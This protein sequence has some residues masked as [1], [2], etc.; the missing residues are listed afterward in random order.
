MMSGKRVVV[1]NPAERE[2]D[3][4]RAVQRLRQRGVA[5]GFP[6]QT[7]E[8]EIIFPVDTNFTLTAD[9]MLMLLESGELD[10][11]GVRRTVEAQAAAPLRKRA[12]AS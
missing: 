8:G 1:S 7:G 10:A 9:Q 5:V 12:A 2:N 4:L 6:M 3:I 11:E